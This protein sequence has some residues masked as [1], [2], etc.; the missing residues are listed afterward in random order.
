MCATRCRQVFLIPNPRATRALSIGRVDAGCRQLAVRVWFSIIESG[1]RDHVRAAPNH[2]VCRLL[3]SG[4]NVVTTRGGFHHPDSLDPGVR[5]RV[6]EA[7]RFGGTS[8][9]STGSSPGFITEAVP[10]V[11]ASIQR[12]LGGLVIDEFADADRRDSP[13]L[14]FDIVGFGKPPAELDE[15]RLAHGKTSFGPSLRARDRLAPFRRRGRATRHRHP[16]SGGSRQV[17]RGGSGVQQPT[18]RSTPYTPSALH[19]RL[20]RHLVLMAW[21]PDPA[22]GRAQLRPQPSDGGDRFGIDVLGLTV[23]RSMAHDRTLS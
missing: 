5:S 23:I 8:I 14:L 13:E 2:R 6:E 7:C 9:H 3:T 22:L 11:P 20:A 15:R 4:A 1:V 10:L 18:A 17:E 21:V 12:R 19:R 16:L